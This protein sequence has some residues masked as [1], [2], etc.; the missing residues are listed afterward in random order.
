MAECDDPGTPPRKITLETSSS[1]TQEFPG[2]YETVKAFHNIILCVA[3]YDFGVSHGGR[4]DVISLV[5]L[6]KELVL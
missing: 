3:L 5:V 2:S 4:N 6:S 1:W